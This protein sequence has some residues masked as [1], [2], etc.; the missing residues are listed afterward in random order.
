MASIKPLRLLQWNCTSANAETLSELTHFLNTNDFDGALLQE[1]RWHDCY[2]PTPSIPGFRVFTNSRNSA[3]SRRKV[4]GGAAIL[5]R[6]HLPATSRQDLHVADS[7]SV[8]ADLHFPDGSTLLLGSVYIPPHK[9]RQIR[10]LSAILSQLPTNAI[11][12]GDFNA[13]SPIWDPSYPLPNAAG[14]A[15]SDII[16]QHNL[17]ILPTDATHFP[18]A[19]DSHSSTID[20]CLCTA[21]SAQTTS[22]STLLEL[23]GEHRPLSI[24][25]SRS[26]YRIPRYQPRPHWR[27]RTA[28]LEEFKQALEMQ[29]SDFIP[30]HRASTL[31]AILSD[32]ETRLHSTAT[33]IIGKTKPPANPKHRSNPWFSPAIK[34]LVAKRRRARRR[35]QRLHTPASIAEYQTANRNVRAAF[36]AAQATFWSRFPSHLPQQASASDLWIRY[37]TAMNTR[38]PPVPIT[39]KKPDGTLTSDPTETCDLIGKAFAKVSSPDLARSNRDQSALIGR[40]L[41]TARDELSS[42]STLG[43]EYN[44]DFTLPE[45]EAAINH[46]KDGAPGQDDLHYS[47]FRNSGPAFR[48]AFLHVIN[49]HWRSA[50]FPDAWK[51]ATVKPIPK[52]GRDHTDPLNFRPISLLS[53]A[54]KLMER[55]VYDRLYWLAES[56]DW[57]SPFQS[58]F[59]RSRSTTQPLIRL[60]QDAQDAFAAHEEVAAAF[61]DLTKA[62]DTVWH[63]ALIYK[64]HRKG[65]RGRLLCWFRDFLTRRRCVVRIGVALSKAYFPSAGVP[66]GSVLSTILF[67][68]FIDD[69]TLNIPRGISIALF[70]DDVTLWVRCD[71]RTIG[72]FD[73]NR[74][75]KALCKWSRNWRMSF[76]PSKSSYIIFTRRRRSPD[77]DAH[78][79][80]NHTDLLLN[81]KPRL[82]GLTLDRGLYWGPHI[83]AILFAANRRLSLI[84]SFGSI[85]F[86]T[87]ES[88]RTLYLTLIRPKL[89]YASCCWSAAT[90]T[91]LQK[92]ER[93]QNDCLRTIAGATP[94]TPINV[95]QADLNIP[96]LQSRWDQSL[97]RATIRHLRLGTHATVAF[98]LPFEKS[99]AYYS[100]YARVSRTLTRLY[101]NS[102]IP[103]LP[104]PPPHPVPVQPPTRQPNQIM[105]RHYRAL[106]TDVS[107]RLLREWHTR[108]SA[109]DHLGSIYHTLRPTIK[110]SWPHSDLSTYRL[111]KTIFRLRASHNNLGAHRCDRRNLPPLTCPFCMADDTTSHLLLYCQQFAAARLILFRSISHLTH[112]LIPNPPTLRHL[113]GNPAELRLPGPILVQMATLVA[114]FA[115]QCRPDL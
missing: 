47:F 59:R 58:G 28:P 29:F 57:M 35:K 80:F 79:R 13:H 46:A 69:V 37:R 7:E 83:Q 82:L 74:G 115:F 34:L 86:A 71:S 41:R 108:Y 55:M 99:H 12:C 70:A 53:C 56:H 90:N 27:L 48:T 10:T 36:R 21:T 33:A 75:L 101:L 68:I 15:L 44:F 9:S 22:A 95:L 113:L 5:L 106:F 98:L 73:L 51:H 114:Q 107:K 72:L 110:P 109:L 91:H 61:L 26:V 18:T 60:V 88:L 112:Y 93:F 30:R 16:S 32:F 4:G 20:L 3:T 81:E 6:N 89:E 43:E 8:W 11:I 92:L 54:G 85:T 104:A 102:L 66:Q 42:I 40:F 25:I 39:L 94:S 77:S 49:S 103:E 50:R 52:P 17:I 1:T 78:P 31:S 96:P 65:I 62:Y 84:R 64:L 19:Q 63:D 87:R 24:S 100:T 2:N 45:L 38:P 23:H 97:I 76:S 67:N 111:S 105:P 14:N